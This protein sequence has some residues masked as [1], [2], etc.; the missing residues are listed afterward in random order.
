MKRGLMILGA[1][2]IAAILIILFYPVEASDDYIEDPSD[3]GIWGQDITINF[4]DGSSSKLK[5]L[6]TATSYRYEDKEVASIGYHLYANVIEAEKVMFDFQNFMITF[7]VDGEHVYDMPCEYYEQMF[8]NSTGEWSDLYIAGTVPIGTILSTTD[9]GDH[10]ITIKP[11]GTYRF[12][13]A[14]G[15]WQTKDDLPDST[16]FYMTIDQTY[17]VFFDFSHQ[18]LF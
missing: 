14:E 7:E 12:R 11:T 1:I 6:P 9:V 18:Y 5:S 4:K 3:F 13:I 17:S 15:T 10:T 2:V 16:T 8:I